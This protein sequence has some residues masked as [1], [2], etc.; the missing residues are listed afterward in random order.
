MERPGPTAPRRQARG[1]PKDR[2]HPTCNGRESSAPSSPVAVVND[3][4]HNPEKI[5]ASIQCARERFGSPLGIV[6][7]PHGFGALR[8]MEEALA[9]HLRRSLEPGDLFMMLPVYYAG[10]TV[11]HHAKQAHNPEDGDSAG[12]TGWFFYEGHLGS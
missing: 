4:A 3:Y 11:K 6:F 5:A 12:L 10:G 7:Q 8:F 2:P 1:R 9:E